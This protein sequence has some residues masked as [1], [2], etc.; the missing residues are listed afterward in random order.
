MSRDDIRDIFAGV[1]ERLTPEFAMRGLNEDIPLTTEPL[2][3]LRDG[4]VLGEIE[5]G[6]CLRWLPKPGIEFAGLFSGRWSPSLDD[7]P[8]ELAAPNLRLT[9]PALLSHVQPNPERP[10]V[11]GLLGKGVSRPLSSADRVQFY[12]VR[13]PD[14]IGDAVLRSTET[15]WWCESGRLTMKAGPL[16]CTL[17]AISEVRELTK[18][19]ERQPGFV[20]SHIGE[21]R[22]ETS[23]MSQ[24]TADN[25]LR[26]LHWFFGFMRGART[27]PILPSV[28]RSFSESWFEIGSWRLDEPNTV[29]SWLPTRSRL[30]LDD[31]FAG[32]LDLWADAVWNDAIR[33]GMSWYMAANAAHVANEVRIPLVQIALELLAWVR[34]VER[35]NAFSEAQFDGL[36]A[37]GRIRTLLEGL[38]IPTAVPARMTELSTYASGEQLDGPGCLTRLRKRLVHPTA[39][40]RR[41][42]NDVDG[43]MYWQAGQL[44][45]QFFELT[46]LALYGYRGK[47][48]CR[49]FR[50]WKGNDEIPVP[51]AMGAG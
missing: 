34:L 14:F 49:A 17:D 16:A 47:Y 8:L 33:T 51:W 26:A 5:G 43:I 2:R 15:S 27:G 38:D 29:S 19:A 24:E 7:Q 28:G 9:G 50:G 36:S 13:F 32:F 22:A 44:G 3:L 11:R 37:N 35:G 39:K 18:L 21:L 25:L 42:L 20:I 40:N 10:V 23:S 45:L 6:L 30:Q 48:A 31:L 4:A 1:P 41:G 12:L 46:L